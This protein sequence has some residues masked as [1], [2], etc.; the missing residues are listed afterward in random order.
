MKTKTLRRLVALAGLLLAGIILTLVLWI[1]NARQL[2]GEQQK[3][4]EKQQSI[5][6]K[7]FNQEEKKFN[8]RVFIALTNIAAK[9]LKLNKDKS[10]PY[11]VVKQLKSNYFVVQINDTLH[12]YLLESLLKREFDLRNIRE[13]FEYG[14]YDCF[15]DSVVYGNYVTFDS[16]HAYEPSINDAQTKQTKFENDGHYFSVFFPNRETFN[17]ASENSKQSGGWFGPEKLGSWLFGTVIV[18]LVLLF[19]VYA[20]SVVL[21]QKRLADVKNDFINNM[22]HE[23]K[24]PIATISLASEVLSRNGI[25][26]EPQ[27]IHQYAGIIKQENKR[28]ENMVERVLRLATLEKEKIELKPD[29]LDVHDLLHECT[30]SFETQ[31]NASGG[32]IIARFNAESSIIN[33]D[34]VHLLNVFSNLVDNAKKYSEREPEIVIETRNKNKGTVISVTDNGIGIAPENLKMIFEKFYRVPTG[35]VH[36]VKGFGLGL[37][38]VKYIVEEHKGQITVTS[39]PGTG[40]TFEVYLPN[41]NNTITHE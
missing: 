24:T 33:G 22:T 32:K 6:E 16:T 37:F 15:T 21:K 39:K 30:R 41:T 35:N 40:T 12:P 9:I 3:L 34:K 18:L 1:S 10:E 23:L 14:I 26:E 4:I 7:A 25:E 13:D 11:N 27:R 38:Y 36:N 5:Q 28:L 31:I 17:V 29:A 8:D 2:V 20:I 19:F